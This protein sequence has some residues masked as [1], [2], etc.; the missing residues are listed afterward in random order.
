[1]VDGYT[2]EL[3]DGLAAPPESVILGCTHYPLVADLF[4]AA[5]PPQVRM[6]SQP[7]ATARALRLY[8]QRH[9]EFDCSNGGS[10]RFLSTGYASD[11]MPLIER[12]WGSE[13]TFEIA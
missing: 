4:A 9:P 13:L 1:M 8:L 6:I 3:L 12:F 11:A 7:D 10:R 2:R 5:L